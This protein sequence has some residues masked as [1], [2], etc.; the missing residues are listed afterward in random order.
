ME[1]NTRGA[2]HRGIAVA[3]V[4]LLAALPLSALAV[5]RQPNPRQGTEIF[6]MIIA[7][8]CAVQEAR[9]NRVRLVDPARC[10]PTP[11]PPTA[12]TL[13]LQKTVINDNGGTATTTD[14][15]ARIEGGNVS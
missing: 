6:E 1:N 14:F 13:T 5:A 3:S 12:P 4:S 15:Q 11:P 8:L 10:V 2:W 7:R 9:G